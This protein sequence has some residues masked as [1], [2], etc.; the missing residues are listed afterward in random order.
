MKNVT[1][2]IPVFELNEDKNTLLL[3]AINSVDDSKIIVVGP[4]TDIDLV[5]NNNI[6]IS[7]DKTLIGFISF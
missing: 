2:I 7:G 1:V 5:K 4:K 3:N 6:E